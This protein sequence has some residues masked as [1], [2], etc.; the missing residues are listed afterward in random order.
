M[1]G[2]RYRTLREPVRARFSVKGSRFIGSASPAADEAAAQ[3]F[4]AAVEEE[5]PDATHHAHAYR[6][7][8]GGVLV[9]RSFDARE[10]AGTAGQPMLQLLQGREL[11]GVVVVGTRYFGGTKLGIGGLTRAYRRCARDCIEAGTVV[12]REEL[13]YC[14]ITV[15][16][17]EIG[18]LLRQLESLQGVVLGTDYGAGV[19]VTA[20]LPCRTAGEMKT[21]LQEITRGSGR[22]EP[23]KGPPR[24]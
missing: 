9:E 12:E 3:T 2:Y 1:S 18:A 5:F 10:P 11:S 24:S 16:Y 8:G 6:I 14:R 15:S 21:R 23:L 17:E 22:W 13:C 19:A 20:A 7:A 4:I